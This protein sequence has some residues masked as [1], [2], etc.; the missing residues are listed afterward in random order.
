MMRLSEHEFEQLLT[1]VLAHAR[2]ALSE[3]APRLGATATPTELRSLTGETIT[4]DGLGAHEVMR[5]YHEVL[6]PACLS[7]GHPRFLS[8]VPAAPT[9][10]AILSEFAVVADNIYAGSWMEG[11][12]AVFGENEALRWIADLAGLPA[13]TGGVFLSGG[14]AGNLSALIAARAKWR[15]RAEGRLDRERP[16]ILAAGGAHSSILQAARVMDADVIRVPADTQGRMLGSAL[17]VVWDEL[18]TADRV[19]VCAIVATAG[20]TNAGVIDDL[21]GVADLCETHEIW[22]HVDGAYGAAALAAPSRRTRFVG[23][24]RADT[25]IVDPHKWWFA[26]YDSCALLYRDPA[27]AKAAHTQQAEYLEVL[28]ESGPQGGQWNP[29]DYAHHLSRRA[30]GLAFWFSLAAYGT[31]AYSEA[32]ETTLRC[33]EVGARLVRER[34]SVDLI[35]EP[36]LSVLLLRRHGWG[37]DDYRAWSTAQQSAGTCFVVPTSW[38]GETVLRFCIV[39]PATTPEDIAAILDT[40]G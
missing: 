1:E 6:A 10:I 28:Q 27:I 20:T 30:R 3:Q 13:T 2:S 16:V 4:P 22:M 33:A 25:L 32:V 39:N 23:I 29:S 12:G 18:S 8:F 15:L 38:E 7:A 37:P 9:D 5:L 24:E 40:L 26:P 17:R 21:R 11:A 19:R 34:Q 31:N 36:E 35:M 14:T